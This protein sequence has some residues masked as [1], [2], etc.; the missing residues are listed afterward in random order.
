MSGCFV[1]FDRH[2]KTMR[3]YLWEHIG[4]REHCRRKAVELA[5]NLTQPACVEEFINQPH[6]GTQVWP[7]QGES[8]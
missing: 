1:V 5:K 7:T 2:N 6:V 3:T 8:K 4:Q